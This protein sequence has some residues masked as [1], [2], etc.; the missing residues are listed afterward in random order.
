MTGRSS[1]LFVSP[2]PASYF[3]GDNNADGADSEDDLY[4]AQAS[5]QRIF[6]PNDP[7]FDER[8]VTAGS[9]RAN[10]VTPVQQVPRVA[11][12]RNP[13]GKRVSIELDAEDEFIFDL[14]RR[15]FKDREIAQRLADE[16]FT[17]YKPQSVGARYARINRKVQERNEELLDLELIDWHEGED[18][19]L[20]KAYDIADERL[21][22]ELQKVREK[23]FTYV[24]DALNSSLDKPRF[25]TKACKDRYEAI[26]N[27]TARP[28]PE[29]DGDPEARKAEQNAKLAQ[30]QELQ[31]AQAKRLAG[32]AAYASTQNKTGQDRQ[33][34]GQRR[35]DLTATTEA[36]K[37]YEQQERARKAS[38][39]E[40]L[41]NLKKQ[42][43]AEYKAEE[44]RKA[45]EKKREA[46]VLEQLRRIA[47]QRARDQGEAAAMADGN[48]KRA[49]L[50][51]SSRPGISQSPMPG[52]QAARASSNVGGAQGTELIRRAGTP[53][54][55]HQLVPFGGL[56]GV[57]F[58]Q[59]AS[60][61][62]SNNDPRDIMHKTELLNLITERGMSRNRDKE[63][64]EVLARRLRDSDSSMPIAVIQQMLRKRNLPAQGTRNE[65]LIRLVES[66][67]MS[68]RLFRPKHMAIF[69]RAR[70]AAGIFSASAGVKRSMGP[71]TMAPPSAKRQRLE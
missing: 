7:P 61:D 16:G 52:A 39:K 11:G 36:K 31:T 2:K 30:Y 8:D 60:G 32:E 13:T 27:G 51:P 67:A 44:A 29:L 25:S 26:L 69:N 18:D 28:P 65:L 55:N 59:F 24:A 20:L 57:Q 14:K 50:G 4:A 48:N 46:E 35:D 38:Y 21:L 34:A 47:R 62:A 70:L 15:G 37:Q 3:G 23:R 43:I 22:A 71:A 68:S 49:S 17:A 58:G 42:N 12:G 66:D 54:S 5:L 9:S 56:P 64:K 53:A 10:D 63:C 6:L 1:S 33:T 40:Q 41:S 45:Q 19:L